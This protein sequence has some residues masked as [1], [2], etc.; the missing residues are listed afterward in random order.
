M[1]YEENNLG[2]E[3]WCVKHVYQYAYNELL[4]IRKIRNYT[5]LPACKMENINHLLIGVLLINPD[6]YTFWNM[7]RYLIEKEILNIYKD[8]TFTKLVL[9]YKSKSN[10]TFAYRRWL[11]KKLF[12]HPPDE[13]TLRNIVNN[14]LEISEV[15]AQK[16]QNNY[17]AWNHRLWSLDL[18]KEKCNLI[19]EFVFNEI[20]FNT[21]WIFSH[22]SEYSGYHYRHII[23]KYLLEFGGHSSLYEK[24]Y[25]QV[26]NSLK[27]AENL[28]YSAVLNELLGP[29]DKEV[30]SEQRNKSNDRLKYVNYISLLLHDLLHI[31]PSINHVFPNHESVWYY[32]RSVVYCVF[33]TIFD[34]LKLER[35]SEFHFNSADNFSHRN[36]MQTGEA[37]NGEK[38]AK[39][40]KYEPNK[41]V[42]SLLYNILVRSECNFVN[43]NMINECESNAINYAKR[44]KDWLQNIV[45]LCEI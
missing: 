34:C 20:Q 22:V 28:S 11:I 32:R 23:F 15:A 25:L 18:L 9:S 16:A 39:L 3:S 6:V 33:K 26:R 12:V 29:C 40:V 14:E 19:Q 35:R 5:A 31:I 7:K 37:T 13:S 30:V 27:S 4:N 1:L 24:Y 42:S 45:K 8:L 10:E 44:H 41:V 17:H 2:L 38:R 36:T 43:I 21:K